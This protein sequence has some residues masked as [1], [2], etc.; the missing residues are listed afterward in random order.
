MEFIAVRDG[1]QAVALSA[2]A[3]RFRRNGAKIWHELRETM[4]VAWPLP[5]SH[6]STFRTLSQ[7][8]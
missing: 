3:G 7:T 5:G 2:L 8:A 1:R 6:A 4:Q